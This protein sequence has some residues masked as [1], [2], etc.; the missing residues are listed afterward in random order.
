VPFFK[1]GLVVEEVDVGGCAVL[2]EV[3]DAFGFGGV[4]GEVGEAAGKGR[5][6]EVAGEE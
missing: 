6:A 5:G 1:G 2:E 4:V 3:D